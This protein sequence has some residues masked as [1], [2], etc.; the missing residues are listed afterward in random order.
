MNAAAEQPERDEDGLTAEDR[1]HN[2]AVQRGAND[3]MD[4]MTG[5]DFIA[6]KSKFG[7]SVADSD[8]MT[9]MIQF[10]FVGFR[11]DGLTDAEA[12]EKANSLPSK[13]IRSIMVDFGGQPELF[14]DDPETPQGKDGSGISP[15]PTN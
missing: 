1:A 8:F 11:R 6:V 2:D 9:N 3:F 7:V 13:K 5:F 12:Y 15:T 4:T 10:A 14:E